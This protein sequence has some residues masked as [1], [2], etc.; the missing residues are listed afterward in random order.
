MKKKR[1][2]VNEK[3]DRGLQK[4]ERK[5]KKSMTRDRER[6]RATVETHD[7]FPVIANRDP[8]SLPIYNLF[9]EA[10]ITSKK[11]F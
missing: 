5:R 4:N 2:S 7:L 11:V 3:K 1:E 6:E 9:R 8:E 10:S